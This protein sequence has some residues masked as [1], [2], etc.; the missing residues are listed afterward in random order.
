MKLFRFVTMMICILIA[1]ALPA[2]AKGKVEAPAEC[3]QCG[4]DRS[5]FSRS[6]MVITYADG[7]SSGTCSIN[8]VAAELKTGGGKKP[9]RLQVA[10]YS[11]GRLIDARKAFW[12]VGGKQKGVMTSVPKWAFATEQDA[13]KFIATVGGK[14]A[15]FD[16]VMQLADG[17]Q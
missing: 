1:G 13:A 16:E 14:A 11:G 15:G 8:C 17:E 7:S 2:V 6:R 12:V 3:K 5:V 10:D 9:G 4:M